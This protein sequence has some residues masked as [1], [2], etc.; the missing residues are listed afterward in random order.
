MYVVRSVGYALGRLSPLL[1]ATETVPLA[2]P[3]TWFSLPVD[4]NVFVAV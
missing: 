2:E 1:A 3:Q 4:F